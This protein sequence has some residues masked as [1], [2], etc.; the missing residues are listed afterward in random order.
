MD[1]SEILIKISTGIQTFFETMGTWNW[2]DITNFIKNVLLGGGTVAGGFALARIVIPL[3]KNSNKPVLAQLG[4]LTEKLLAVS[5]QVVSLHQENSTLRTTL[6]SVGSYL[7]TTANINLSSK[8]L[9]QAQKDQLVTWLNQYHTAIGNS[10]TP[11]VEQ[12]NSVI[13]DNVITAQEIVQL[14]ETVPILEKALGTPISQLM[15][16]SGA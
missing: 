11:T 5:E 7:E 2:V 12:I 16:K 10:A 13:A 1:F 8:T 6:A 15:P 9:T 14:A 3:L 4:A